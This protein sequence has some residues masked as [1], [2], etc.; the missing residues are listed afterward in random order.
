MSVLIYH[1][2]RWG[3]SRAS[4]GIL[5]QKNIDYKIVTYIDSPLTIE[6]LK[7]IGKKLKLRPKDFI[8]KNEKEFKQLNLSLKLDDD[9]NLLK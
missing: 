7:Q 3:K 1:N 8:R 4:V 6:G 5:D 9:G 2:P